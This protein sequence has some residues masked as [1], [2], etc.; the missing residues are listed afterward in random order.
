M[1]RFLL[2]CLLGLGGN[3]IGAAGARA[4]AQLARA[5][6]LRE[7][8]L[9]FDRVELDAFDVAPAEF[10]AAEA[11]VAPA[12]RQAMVEAAQRIERL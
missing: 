8:T 6:R 4:L 9:R 1:P 12:L 2:G 7:L 5:P 11:A 3:A 10:A